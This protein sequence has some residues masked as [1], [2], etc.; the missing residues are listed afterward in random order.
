MPVGSDQEEEEEEE[1]EKRDLLNKAKRRRK[2]TRLQPS[3][4]VQT[5]M[6]GFFGTPSSWPEHTNVSVVDLFCCIGGFSTGC[7]AAGHRLVLAVDCDENALG[8]HAANHPTCRH[9]LMELGPETEERLLEIL[10]ESLPKNDDGTEILPWHLH[11]SPPCQKLCSLLF[12]SMLNESHE[13]RENRFQEG[14]RMV[15]WYLDFV[16]TCFR[17]LN[18]TSWSFEEA[19]NYRLF[20]IMK[21]LKPSRAS[22]FDVELVDFWNF[23]VPQTRQRTIGGSPWLIDR[24]RHDGRIRETR[25]IHD[26]LSPPEGAVSIRSVWRGDRNESLDVLDNDTGEK[27]NPNNERRTR[28][29]HELSFTVMAAHTEMYWHDSQMERVRAVSIEERK[30]LQTFPPDYKLPPRPNDQKK[31]IG[32]AIPPLFAQKFM[33]MY[34]PA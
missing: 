13:D 32:N 22:W 9:E 30:R 1:P 24:L 29:L 16:E 7:A 33:S 31:G 6:K 5:T 34:R 4:A 19:P 20:E 18:L 14:M 25:V 23:G 3:R 27:I 28:L 2:A 26:V 8:A 10:R 15:T 11:G 12:T 17:T 21:K